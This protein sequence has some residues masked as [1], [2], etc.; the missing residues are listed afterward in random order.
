MTNILRLAASTLV[1]LATVIHGIQAADPYN[2]KPCKDPYTCKEAPVITASPSG[3]SDLCQGQ[4]GTWAVNGYIS[5][6]KKQKCDETPV[7]VT[8]SGIVWGY[9]VTGPDGSVQTSGGSNSFTWTPALT[10]AHT[11]T[12]TGYSS[13]AEPCQV[14]PVKK[15]QTFNVEAPRCSCTLGSVATC[16]GDTAHLPWTITN[17]SSTCTFTYYWTAYVGDGSPTVTPMIK[18]GSVSVGPGQTVPGAVDFDVASDSLLGAKAMRFEVACGSNANACSST[19]VISVENKW[20]IQSPKD[21]S[22]CIGTEKDVT[23]TLKNDCLHAITVDWS[24]AK[25]NGTPIVAVTPPLGATL[26]P[27][28]GSVPITVKVA[29]APR[30][31]GGV[32]A[33]QIRATSGGVVKTGTFNVHAFK[34]TGVSHDMEVFQKWFGGQK[35]KAQVTYEGSLTGAEIEY[36]LYNIEEKQTQ[37]SVVTSE[38]QV[39]VPI[40]KPG[41]Y[42]ISVKACDVTLEASPTFTCY[43]FTLVPGSLVFDWDGG[44]AKRKLS[45]AFKGVDESEVELLEDMKDV[46]DARDYLASR[47]EALDIRI[48]QAQ[49]E[50][51]AKKLADEAE[52]RNL[53]RQIALK[54]GELTLARQNLE[55]IR[56]E[57]RNLRA[58][59]DSLSRQIERLMRRG[60]PEDIALANQLRAQLQPLS[61]ALAQIPA[62]L[63]AAR[64]VIT[65]LNALL[66]EMRAARSVFQASVRVSEQ[67]IQ[68]YKTLLASTLSAGDKVRAL[69]GVVTTWKRATGN[70]GEILNG[71]TPRVKVFFRWLGPV[72][73]IL[74]IIEVLQLDEAKRKFNEKVALLEQKYHEL[75]DRLLH[76]TVDRIPGPMKKQLKIKSVPGRSPFRLSE[77]SLS[78]KT[79]DDEVFTS[80]HEEEWSYKHLVLVNDDL[81]LYGTLL[82]TSDGVEG[83]YVCD[84]YAYGNIGK[85]RL[86]VKGFSNE[87]CAAGTMESKGITQDEMLKLAE[88]LYKDYTIKMDMIKGNMKVLAATASAVLGTFALV[89]AFTTLS[90]AA[91]VAIIAA[92]V[93]LIGVLAITLFDWL[94]KTDLAKSIEAAYPEEM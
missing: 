60:R 17:P 93:G 67:A 92:L 29:V 44:D 81:G 80:R 84:V 69:N 38:A 89:L 30:S 39:D 51:E 25:T 28:G 20:G 13:G 56:E 27:A 19:A 23:F 82:S 73:V 72:G 91:P 71:L 59:V 64:V 88:L 77:D 86:D 63:E 48:E 42:K 49:K 4:S 6:G 10:G 43:Q 87:L 37:W 58:E 36:V 41:R 68:S 35:A 9:V 54:E 1:L 79:Q 70:L 33:M 90:I 11:I 46:G 18:S 5:D 12:W 61:T 85:S 26:V 52:V 65:D 22:I 40:A 62:R 2:P 76:V 32:A 21:Q 45:D 47:A 7:T 94:T 55:A 16:P 15:T 75:E 34:I 24:V 57:G 78:W 14:G 74:D 3:P 83:E 66:P 50:V 53:D 31:P 8:P